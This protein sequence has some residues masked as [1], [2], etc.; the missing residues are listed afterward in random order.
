MRAG[1]RG[2]FSAQSRALERAAELS[3]VHDERA[4]RLVAAARIALRAAELERA[5]A[6]VERASATVQDPVIRADAIR[7]RAQIESW[8]GRSISSHDLVLEAERIAPLSTEIAS[9]LLA[10]NLAHHLT[11]YELDS[12]EALVQRLGPM[13][14]RPSLQLRSKLLNLALA[15]GRSAEAR[16]LLDGLVD[17]GHQGISWYLLGLGR[18]E[19]ARTLAAR[20]I[21]EQRI[22]GGLLPLALEGGMLADAEQRLGRFAEARAAAAESAQFAA[23]GPFALLVGGAASTLAALNAI[24]G[25]EH[26]ARAQA[27][28]ALEAAR[29][30]RSAALVGFAGIALGILALG[31]NRPADAVDELR[32]IAELVK[33]AGV[34]NPALLPYAPELIEAF[35][36][37]GERE[38]AEAELTRF[39]RQA[40]SLEQ[41]WA[42][43]I[44]A[45]LRGYLAGDAELDHH[46]GEALRPR[47]AD[48]ASPF[49]RAR[50]RLLYGERLR[51]A[52]R[53]I[54]AREQL[55][56]A[57]EAFDELG[58][59]PWAERARRE[60][61]ASGISIPRRDPTAPEKLTPQELQIALQVTEGKTNKEVA[62]ALFLSTKTVEFH[63]TRV[64]RKLELHS[65]G[66][67][68]RLFTTGAGAEHVAVREMVAD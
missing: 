48:S 17:S 54:D 22:L 60:L 32:P 66:E 62:A 41:S 16:E 15:R 68:I 55:R 56:A 33:R 43:A 4:R 29:E 26:E 40:N 47:D 5:L 31:L 49:E 6:L 65:R 8:F 1:D 9:K 45:R 57:V 52:R 10:V 59:K 7:A 2:G 13:A 25:E 42:L 14:E 64:Y 46:F 3:P 61:G 34:D 63:L 39:E 11:S 23:L 37:T 58:A 27:A 38:A 44:A 19:Q 53:R 18:F 51:R 12:A 35:V 21:A 36:L 28:V 24:Q 30:P 50:T 67:L 20:K